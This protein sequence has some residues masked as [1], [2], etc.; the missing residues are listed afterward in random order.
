VFHCSSVLGSVFFSGR[1]RPIG[2]KQLNHSFCGRK[3]LNQP[4]KKDSFT[5]T[6]WLNWP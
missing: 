1:M 2:R 4:Q 5:A 6:L 3:Q